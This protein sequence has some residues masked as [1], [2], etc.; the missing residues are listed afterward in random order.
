MASD[1]FTSLSQHYLFSLVRVRHSVI[2]QFIFLKL[3]N[4]ALKN[5]SILIFLRDVI[6][7]DFI[8]LLYCDKEEPFEEPHDISRDGG[9]LVDRQF[10]PITVPH[11]TTRRT[12]P[13]LFLTGKRKNKKVKR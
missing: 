6:S 10:I 13:L 4:D 12:Y 7:L 9:I 5:S 2:R 3:I 8:S 11:P 1:A